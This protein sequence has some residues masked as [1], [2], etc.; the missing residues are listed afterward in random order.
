MDLSVSGNPSYYE[1]QMAKRNQIK[2]TGPDKPDSIWSRIFIDIFGLAMIY[3]ST[4]LICD[5]IRKFIVGEGK[6]WYYMFTAPPY[7]L[8]T[9]GIEKNM[10][11]WRDN[12]K[13][14][15]TWDLDDNHPVISV[16]LQELRVAYNRNWAAVQE[17][18]IVVQK[19]DGTLLNTL[20]RENDRGKLSPKVK[21]IY[22]TFLSVAEGHH[23]ADYNL[24][25]YNMAAVNYLDCAKDFGALLY[26][27][28]QCAY[29]GL[30]GLTNTYNRCNWVTTAVNKWRELLNGYTLLP[31]APSNA[32]ECMQLYQDLL[33]NYRNLL[34]HAYTPYDGTVWTGGACD[35]FYTNQTSLL[36]YTPH[37]FTNFDAV[38]DGKGEICTCNPPP[39]P[40]EP[41]T[42]SLPPPTSSNDWNIP[43]EIMD[44][45]I[46]KDFITCANSQQNYPTANFECPYN[47]ISGAEYAYAKYNKTEVDQATC[48]AI[49]HQTYTLCNDYYPSD[50][51]YKAIEDYP[52]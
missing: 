6:P 51:C 26:Q 1:V 30:A 40:Q 20:R 12:D 36:A 37:T 45:Y 23:P 7:Y 31:L 16:Y 38:V 28:E 17:L 35:I 9:G 3:A 19:I 13:R 29:E 32:Q 44:T 39:P 42:P 46:V 41:S 18:M 49:A 14:Y 8:G 22:E 21:Q 5:G 24:M 2:Y 48:Q 52:C 10:D 50:V 11:K 34:K 47:L 4:F 25:L 33:Y 43:P 15:G 27:I